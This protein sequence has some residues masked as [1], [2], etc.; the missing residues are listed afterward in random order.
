MCHEP[1]TAGYQPGKNRRLSPVS[2]ALGSTTPYSPC[3]LGAG[4]KG[5]VFAYTFLLVE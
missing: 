5:D 1:V 2:R 4:S 3:A